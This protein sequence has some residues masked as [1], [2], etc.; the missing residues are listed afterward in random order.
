M[1]KHFKTIKMIA[2]KRY[3]IS[4]VEISSGQYKVAYEILGKT[5]IS[6]SMN[7]YNTASFLFEMKRVELDGN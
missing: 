6:E 2:T 4:I 5:V 3:E 1:T 7:D